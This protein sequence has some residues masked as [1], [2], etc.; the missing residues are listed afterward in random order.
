MSNYKLEWKLLGAV[1]ILL[2]GCTKESCNP[3]CAAPPL[4][5]Y[6]RQFQRTLATEIEAAPADAAFPLAIQDCALLRHQIR[7]GCKA[8]K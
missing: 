2:S 8:K 1:L 4:K 6:D 5:E 7:A 3:V